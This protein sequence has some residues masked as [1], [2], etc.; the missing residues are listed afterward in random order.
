MPKNKNVLIIG[1]GVHGC[2]MAKYL[3]K[4]NLNIHIIE[5]KKDICLGASN[6]THNRALDYGPG[7]SEFKS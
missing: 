7:G 4:Y 3:R 6:A 5:K 1:A 2:F